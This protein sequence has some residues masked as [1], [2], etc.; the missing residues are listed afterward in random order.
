M[1]DQVGELAGEE[2]V[3]IV[4]EGGGQSSLTAA[5]NHPAGLLA[6]PASRGRRS[7]RSF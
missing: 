6:R 7:W 3:G 5:I 4:A 2:G 1:P